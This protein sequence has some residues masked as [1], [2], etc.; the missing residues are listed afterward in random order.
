MK[1]VIQLTHQDLVIPYFKSRGGWSSYVFDA[2]RFWTYRSAEKTAI[3]L[4]ITRS[5][6]PETIPGELSVVRYSKIA[7]I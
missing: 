2:T 6:D 7:P 1:Y 3:E 5:N 4:S